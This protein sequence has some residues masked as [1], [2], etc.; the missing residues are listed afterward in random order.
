LA[1]EAGTTPND[2]LV[3]LAQLSYRE[4]QRAAELH[5]IADDRWAAFRRGRAQPTAG[6][7]A[8][9]SEDELVAASRTFSED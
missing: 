2:A 9:L 4:H 6:Q 7:S 8:A 3:Q 1:E 5:R